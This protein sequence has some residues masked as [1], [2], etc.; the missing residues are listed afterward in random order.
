MRFCSYRSSVAATTSVMP[1]ERAIV[2][3]RDGFLFVPHYDFST[4]PGLDRVLVPAGSNAEAKS[5]VIPVWSG[6][7]PGRAVEDIYGNVGA[8]EAAYDATLRD[9]ARTRSA[10]LAQSTATGLFYAT[11]APLPNAAPPVA[12][13]LV[14]LTR[15]G[16]G[17]AVLFATT[18]LRRSRRAR[19]APVPQPA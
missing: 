10:S 9:L 4:V 11:G 17:A 3:S 2:R 14:A 16:L 13:V 6:I 18:H 15:S 1:P 8:G 7:Q 19:F 5:G 12:E